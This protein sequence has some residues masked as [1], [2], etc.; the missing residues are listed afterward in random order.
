MLKLA[1]VISDLS[2]THRACHF[3]M[4]GKLDYFHSKRSLSSKNLHRSDFTEENLTC[5]IYIALLYINRLFQ[6]FLKQDFEPNHNRNTSTASAMA[7]TT[8]NH[9]GAN[10]CS[11][12]LIGLYGTPISPRAIWRHFAR[13]SHYVCYVKDPICQLTACASSFRCVNQGF[14]SN[15]HRPTPKSGMKCSHPMKA[16]LSANLH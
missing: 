2:V 15:Y 4:G 6:G 3:S 16:F 8:S 5:L 11:F 13:T 9:F 14:P 10:E 12:I 7:E 1:C